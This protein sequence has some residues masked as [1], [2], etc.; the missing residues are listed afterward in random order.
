MLNGV[1]WVQECMSVC[2]CVQQM[3]N[4]GDFAMPGVNTGHRSNLEVM[5]QYELN[6][7]SINC[8]RRIFSSFWRVSISPLSFYCDTTISLLSIADQSQ[9]SFLR[10]ITCKVKYT[11]IAVRSL[12][13]HTTS[14]THMPCR[15]TVLPATRQR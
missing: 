13:C 14:G 7:A 2:V 6:V 11:D 1:G 5:F 10:N 12:T 4:F 8:F 3:G 9:L 15:I